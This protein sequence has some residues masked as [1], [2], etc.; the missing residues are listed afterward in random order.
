[1]WVEQFG[2][3]TE[4]DPEIRDERLDGEKCHFG[5]IPSSTSAL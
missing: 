3:L 2:A 4:G 1:M 5:K